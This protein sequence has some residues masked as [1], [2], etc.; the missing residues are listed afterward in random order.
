MSMTVL[1]DFLAML[2]FFGCAIAGRCLSNYFRQNCLLPRLMKA[3]KAI[4]DADDAEQLEEASSL[5]ILPPVS[6]PVEE[7]APHAGFTRVVP[8]PLPL[9]SCSGVGLM[10]K[11]LV[12]E[13]GGGSSCTMTT[14]TPLSTLSPSGWESEA[15]HFGSDT[16]GHAHGMY[17]YTECAPSLPTGPIPLDVAPADAQW[18]TDGATSY[19]P[20]LSPTGHLLYTD[21]EMVFMLACVPLEDGQDANIDPNVA[22][23]AFNQEGGS[24]MGTEEVDNDANVNQKADELCSVSLLAGGTT[25][26]KST[27][28]ADPAD[29]DVFV[30]PRVQSSKTTPV[31]RCK[32]VNPPDFQTIPHPENGSYRT[33]TCRD[34][35]K[36]SQK[37]KAILAKQP[38][39]MRTKLD[40][41]S[42][43]WP[44]GL[45]A[46]VVLCIAFVVIL[47]GRVSNLGPGKRDELQSLKAE[48]AE[49]QRTVTLGE[50][51]TIE[52]DMSDLLSSDLGEP[53][54]GNLK[55]RKEDVKKLRE[56]FAGLSAA[57]LQAVPKQTYTHFIGQ[58]KELL[59]IARASK[60]QQAPSEEDIC[61]GGGSPFY[62]EEYPECPV[63]TERG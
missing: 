23:T 52:I 42:C 33:P 58:M 35:K 11:E 37:A 19:E 44:F 17:I 59:R 14:A 8:G 43:Q 20:L 16:S 12:D 10:Q 15:D 25:E 54:R 9:V 61:E 60:S 28:A 47:L 51:K 13:D 62:Q 46:T 32:D 39:A 34:P 63:E 5:Q 50:M 26:K 3:S 38:S 36:R 4:H 30:N 6:V 40:S 24:C 21:G 41:R 27:S 18:Y 29:P 7:A 57:D 49:L 31:R 53:F 1:P 22:G 2:M 48:H 55:K 56:A 45:K